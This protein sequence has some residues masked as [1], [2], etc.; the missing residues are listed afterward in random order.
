MDGSH[1]EIINATLSGHRPVDDRTHTSLA[2]LT[3]RLG[4]V[5]SHG[6]LYAGVELSPHMER[7]SHRCDALPVG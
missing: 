1:F 6:G 3:E 4:D 2:V 5:K 7:L